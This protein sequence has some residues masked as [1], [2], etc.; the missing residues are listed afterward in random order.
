MRLPVFVYGTTLLAHTQRLITGRTFPARPARLGGFRRGL[1]EGKLFP[2]LRREAGSQVFGALLEQV[3]HAH[4]DL[5]DL[6]EG[7]R[8]ERIRVEVEVGPGQT[9]PA[10]AWLLVG[11]YAQRVTDAPFDLDR[12]L[13][14][15]LEAFSDQLGLPR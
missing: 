8:W 14:Y 3:E 10:W 4:L 1:V 12:Y 7:E 5:L 6:Y 11:P 9:S 15:D 13:S 2:S